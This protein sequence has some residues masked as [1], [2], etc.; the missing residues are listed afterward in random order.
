MYDA[1]FFKD[2][3][4]LITGGSGSIGS[5][6]VEELLKTDC[7]AIR[8]LTNSEYELFGIQK[9]YGFNKKLRFLLGDV[10]DKER[11][12]VASDGVNIVFHAAA[13]K[14]V[15][16]CEFNPFDAI[17]TNVIGTQNMIEACIRNDVDRFVFI[18]TDKAANPSSTLG[19]TKLLSERLTISA[20]AY[21]RS[22][23]K[24]IMYCVR[25]GNVLGTRGSVT[26]LFFEQIKHN[27]PLTITHND[28]TRFTMTKQEAVDLILSTVSI[29]KG[30]E[31]F[32][33]KMKSMRIKDL[34]QALIDLYSPNPK[35]HNITEIGIRDGE[36][37]HEDLITPDEIPKVKEMNG[38][39]VIPPTNS[40]YYDK[41]PSIKTEE[42][43]SKLCSFMSP[44]EIKSMLKGLKAEDFN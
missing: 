13:L 26:E 29:A 20:M 7:K 35:S 21:R 39:Y 4:I 34:A 25:F 41:L 9:K 19:A 33:L 22:L 32:V 37:L 6:L 12:N 38:M 16:L 17:Q 42:Y 30:G 8:V 11:L 27:K 10:R 5:Y 15:P 1:T 23:S 36:K 43:S 44:D 3:T 28:M 31:I 18:S 24:P 40:N 2:K 14:H